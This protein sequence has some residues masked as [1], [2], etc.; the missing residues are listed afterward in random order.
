MDELLLK[1]TINYSENAIVSKIILNKPNGSI[2][3]FA[4]DKEQFISEHTTPYD[5][6]VIILEG[7]AEIK[8]AEKIHI[9][10]EGMSIMMPANTPH[11]LKAMERFKMLLA[12]IK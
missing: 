2:T 7:T 3:A 11:S 12:M 8:V 10:N 6:L 9:L 1:D 5:A 4:L